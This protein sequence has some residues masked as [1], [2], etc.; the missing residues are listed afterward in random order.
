M[1]R[2]IVIALLLIIS[3]L[4]QTTLNGAITIG[5]TTP[6]LLLILVCVFA[7]LRGKKEGLF[8]GFFAGVLVDLF[9]GYS[10]VIGFNALM[11]MYIGYS[12]GIFHDI[13]YT[14][15][16]TIPLAF[17]AAADLAY[18]F[19]YYVL[20]FALRNKL[21]LGYYFIKIML[22]ELIYTVFLTIFLYKLYRIIND[23][24][25]KHE[26]RGENNYGS[27]DIRDFI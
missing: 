15:D 14:D 10:N 7:L 21:D 16:I 25:E 18:N 5:N 13:I 19:I 17:T 1:I 20:A 8:I 6:N 9:Y 22:P 23:K 4:C 12:V 26:K 27:R 24:L 11:Y 2:K 3:Y